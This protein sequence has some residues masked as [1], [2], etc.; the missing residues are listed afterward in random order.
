[1]AS[2]LIPFMDILKINPLSGR[3]PLGIFGVLW[4]LLVGLSPITAHAATDFDIDQYEIYY[5]DFN[6]DGS[7]GDVY[8]HGL[9]KIILL[10]GSIITPIEIKGAS[11]FAYYQ[12]GDGSPKA[13]DIPKNELQYYTKVADH[14]GYT[15]SDLNSDGRLDIVIR[16]SSV[17]EE[18]VLLYSPG[19]GTF[20]MEVTAPLLS[21]TESYDYDEIGRLIEVQ[22]SGNNRTSYEYDDADNRRSKSTT[23]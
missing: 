5:G 15:L 22:R 8:F 11:G 9:E 1:M 3:I 7:D 2:L 21:V 6:G 12:N 18:Q 14:H 23:D 20:Q 10:H 13:L 16:L 4:I 17:N 19:S